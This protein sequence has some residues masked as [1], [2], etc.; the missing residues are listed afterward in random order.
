MARLFLLTGLLTAGLA[1]AVQAQDRPP[2][3]QIR[4]FIP[5]E[6]LVSFLPST[7]FNRFVEFLDP[8][9]QRV[10]GKQIIDPE[11]RTDAIGISIASWHFL[12]AFEQV[13][14]VKGLTYRE[15]DRFFIIEPAPV[16][17]PLAVFDANAATG[18]LPV[19][20]EELAPATMETRE[21]QI[22]AILF[23]LNNIKARDVGLDWSVIF[24]ENQN[25]GGQ[26]GGQG[27]QG[28]QNQ[29]QGIN[30]SLKTSDFFDNFDAIIEG[31]D[32][33]QFRDLASFFRLLED[34]GIGETIAN[35]SVTVQSGEL[36]RMQVGTDVPVQVRDFSGNTITQ[37]FS[38]GIII[39][40]T[41]TFIE[42]ALVDTLGSPTFDFVHLQAQVEK[43]SSRPTASGPAIDRSSANTQ[44]LLL[45]G[46]Q[47]VIGGL[48]STDET[49]SRRGI[50]VLKD[51]PPWFFGLRFIFGRTQRS[52]TQKELFIVIQAKLMD[53]LMVR[54][55]APLS[56]EL[57]ERARRRVQEQIQRFEGSAERNP[58]QKQ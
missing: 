8:I 13:L 26:Q 5:P 37:F 36:G 38:T 27:G 3:R 33:V 49:V 6:Q 40:V 4:S 58:Y 30:L 29:Q 34:N 18:R 11:S 39:N 41:P 25:Q 2:E 44:V 10:T 23:E 46:E 17:D 56:T 47:T 53:P 9:F 35:P 31:P 1:P 51:L 19:A 21:V 7:P 32:V 43:S 50:P 28:G 57:L 12:D 22:N 15:T 45:D 42:E 20:A 55:N 14:A 48:Y 52:V 24:G 54:A 16:D